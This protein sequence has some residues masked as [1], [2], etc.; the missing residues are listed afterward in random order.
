MK[1]SRLTM[2]APV[3]LAS[4]F[5]TSLGVQ[6]LTTVTVHALACNTWLGPGGSPAMATSG[7]WSVATNWSSGVTPI[8]SDN[9]C[10]TAPGTYTVTLMPWSIGTADPEHNGSEVSS[11]TLGGSSGQQT[12]IV[13]GQ[14]STSNSNEPVNNVFLNPTGS[15]TINP[16]GTLILDST[17]SGN[18]SPPAHN[19][20]SAWILGGPLT[21]FGHIVAQTED[22]FPERGTLI[23]MASLTNAP[24]ATIDLESGPMILDGGTLV[25]HG[26]FTVAQPASLQMNLST[27][28]SDI[29]V[30]ESSVINAGTIDVNSATWNQSAGSV[31]GHAIQINSGSTLLDHAGRAQFVDAVLNSTL[32]GMIPRGQ[33]VTVLGTGPFNVS[34]NQSFSTSVSFNGTKVVNDGTLVLEATGKGTKTGGSVVLNNGTLINNGSVIARNKDKSWGVHLQVGLINQRSGS[35]SVS[36]GEL[37]QDTGTPTDNFGRVALSADSTYLV[38]A[39]S[40]TNSRGAQISSQIGGPKKVGQF[41]LTVGGLLTAGGTLSL[42]TVAGYR[43]AQR[44][45]FPLVLLGGGRYSGTFSSVPH[46]F[47]MDLKGESA[48]PPFV[49]VSF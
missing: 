2:S 34:G 13:S 21:N 30:N 32:E 16:S 36:G 39:G 24:G 25:N 20:A 4:V 19:G 6:S 22:T 46:G 8:P 27:S 29:F 18:Q 38:A 40:F 43:P 23:S 41:I 14:A 5:L 7:D 10:I 3:V 42:P 33:I 12:L 17:N 45:I 9:V 28:S 31:K 1:W 26:T 35:F 15:S 37:Y 11:L 49:G 48:S 47:S 44:T